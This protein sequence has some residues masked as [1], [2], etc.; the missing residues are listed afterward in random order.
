MLL[1]EKRG[2]SPIVLSVSGGNAGTWTLKD[3]WQV[4]STDN[5]MHSC[6]G[7]G[8]KDCT[9]VEIPVPGGP[10]GTPEGNAKLIQ[11]QG[12]ERIDNNPVGR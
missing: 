5:S 8:A 7:T 10:Q 2:L 12:G 3:L 1:N 4:F 6:Y 11:Y 9:Q